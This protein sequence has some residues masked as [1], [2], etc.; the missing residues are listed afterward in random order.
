MTDKDPRYPYTY[1]NDYIRQTLGLQ[2]RAE[3][4][5]IVEIQAESM[6]IDKEMCARLLA[7]KFLEENR[8][9]IN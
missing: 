5:K 9:P 4:S 7:D 3:A 2:S 6:G 8:K 1:A